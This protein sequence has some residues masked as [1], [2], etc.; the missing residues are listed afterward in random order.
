[1][2]KVILCGR[3]TADPE[4]R[5]TQSGIASCR[6][7]L[8]VNR[9]YKKDGETEADFLVC[10][11]WRQT[12]ETIARYCTKGQLILVEGSLR[13]N[14]YQD[15][16]HEDVMHY[17][18]DILVDRFEFTEKKNNASDN[19]QTAPQQ[20]TNNTAYKTTA[21]ANYYPQAQQTA[22][23]AAPQNTEFNIS[24]F[25]EILSDNTVPF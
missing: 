22:T 9:P 5:T 21:N 15:R 8:A 7:T 1:M 18:N 24:D 2:N 10:V 4:L 20:P 16:N 13:N 11:A 23:Q 25:E 17:T 3:L 19:A 12:A 14:N 6:F